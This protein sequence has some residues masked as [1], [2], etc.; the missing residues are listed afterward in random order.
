MPIG[1]EIEKRGHITGFREEIAKASNIS[2]DAFFTW[3]NESKDKDTSFL[4]GHW[5]FAFHIL[6]P[7]WRFITAPEDKTVLEIGYGGGRLL[8]AASRYFSFVVGVDIHENSQIVH[9]ELV[10]AGITNFRLINTNGSS[11][12]LESENID[13]VYSFIVLQHVEKYEIFVSYLRETYRVLKP[14]GIAVLYF[15]RKTCFSPNR[16]SRLLVLADRV[17]EKILLTRGFRERPARVN[18]INLVIGKSHAKRL[19]KS[20]GFKIL[21][22]MVSRKKVPDGISK[23]GGQHG[24]VLAKQ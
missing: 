6:R 9:D 11:I 1:N 14:G 21:E 18:E 19:V 7:S 4:R 2:E 8:A 10:A 22:E 23:F 13:F 12:P 24:L 3:F 16:R 5:D 15:G 17:L 20:I